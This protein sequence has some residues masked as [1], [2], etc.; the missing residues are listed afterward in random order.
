MSNLALGIV[1]GASVSGGFKSAVQS[2][3]KN[4]KQL[5][6]SITKTNG[7]VCYIYRKGYF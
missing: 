1:V 2:A 5:G 4:I 6:D 3:D 7:L